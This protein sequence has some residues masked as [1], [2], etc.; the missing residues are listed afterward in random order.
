M[1]FKVHYTLLPLFLLIFYFAS[2]VSAQIFFT[3]RKPICIPITYSYTATTSATPSIRVP[4]GCM[5]ATVKLW[6]AGG[7]S[8]GNGADIL[9]TAGADGGAGAGGGYAEFTMIVIG[10]HNYRA[11]LGLGG[12]GGVGPGL[13][14]GGDSAGGAGGGGASV[15][16]RVEPLVALVAVAAGGGG[17]G[18]G[19]NAAAGVGGRGGA[20]GIYDPLGISSTGFS[21]TDGAALLNSAGF[22]GTISAGGL[23][24]SILQN[25]ASPVQAANGILM[26]G[27]VGG[28]NGGAAGAAGG[29]GGNGGVDGV[30]YSQSGGSGGNSGASSRAGGGGAGSG[31]Y[32][33]G[34]GSA[35]TVNNAGGG[36]GGGGST[37]IAASTFVNGTFVNS[38][39]AASAP[40]NLADPDRGG[41][42]V[43]YGANPSGTA[44]G[45]G[46][47]GQPGRIVVQFY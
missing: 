21:G 15:L 19:D 6:G 42:T 8:G 18:G 7:G 34:G 10:N 14:L 17:G 13:S 46:L 1:F 32:G 40:A 36:G 43:G 47:T 9:F 2:S 16:F 11:H 29:T 44:G 23:A 22:G 24:G 33:G 12:T 37:F 3:F 45:T 31:Y 39:A 38:P 26:G 4:A 5:N 41:G 30:T 35:A 20:A 27:G 28:F 25:G